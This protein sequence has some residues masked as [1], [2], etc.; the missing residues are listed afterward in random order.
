MEQQEKKGPTDTEVN[1][2]F[3]AL[4]KEFNRLWDNSPKD[5]EKFESFKQRVK[6]AILYPRQMDAVVARCN[7]VINGTYGNTKKPEH[8]EQSKSSK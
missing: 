6:L 7:N 1:A 4:L 5:I 3:D 2:K 8:Y